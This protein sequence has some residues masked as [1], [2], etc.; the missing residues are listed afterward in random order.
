MTSD[1]IRASFNLITSS[2]CVLQFAITILSV[3]R[4]QSAMLHN[5]IVYQQQ[6]GWTGHGSTPGYACNHAHAWCK[7]PRWNW[8][9]H[10]AEFYG[11]LLTWRLYLFRW[12]ICKAVGL[13][14]WAIISM[15]G[16]SLDMITV[17]PMWTQA[18]VSC[19]SKFDELDPLMFVIRV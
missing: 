16:T 18:I 17:S 11:R 19:W 15:T 3:H 8:E 7:A 12:V 2:T 1:E 5:V 13:T 10:F 14:H 6:S 9:K 4:I